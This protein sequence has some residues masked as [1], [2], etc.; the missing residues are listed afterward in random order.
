M[1]SLDKKQIIYKKEFRNLRSLSKSTFLQNGKEVR[2]K[3]KEYERKKFFPDNKDEKYAS[4]QVRT[5]ERKR[6]NKIYKYNSPN[7]K[8]NET[9]ESDDENENQ[10]D[11]ISIRMSKKMIDDSVKNKDVNEDK[12][13]KN[14]H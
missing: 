13:I 7:M 4:S 2:G 10:N 9:K 3:S 14:K 11:S 1:K 6:K 12:N 8:R 5:K